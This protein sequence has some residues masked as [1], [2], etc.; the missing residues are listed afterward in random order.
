VKEG[1]IDQ[2]QIERR[3]GRY[4]EDGVAEVAVDVAELLL[5]GEGLL[6]LL[7][8]VVR[9]EEAAGLG[10]GGRHHGGRKH[11]TCSHPTTC[12]RRVF[13]FVV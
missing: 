8:L 12:A 10:L 2:A 6:L 11:S 9:E 3:Q 7:P 1:T 4:H 13:G 5:L